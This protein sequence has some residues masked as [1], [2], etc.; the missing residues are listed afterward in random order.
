MAEGIAVGSALAPTVHGQLE[1]A[2]APFHEPLLSRWG[3]DHFTSVS[4]SAVL[5]WTE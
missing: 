1:W 4:S 2:P 5:R 3:M